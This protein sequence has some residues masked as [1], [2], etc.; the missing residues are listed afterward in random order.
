MCHE[1]QGQCKSCATCV[2]M[3]LNEYYQ[4]TVLITNLTFCHHDCMTFSP[5]VCNLSFIISISQVTNHCCLHTCAY[6]F[7]TCN[8]FLSLAELP[9]EKFD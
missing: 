6:L 4:C 8:E 9:N 1:I 2:F 7:E 5:A 3:A